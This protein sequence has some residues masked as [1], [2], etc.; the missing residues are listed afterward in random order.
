MIYIEQLKSSNPKPPISLVDL[1]HKDNTLGNN[2]LGIYPATHLLKKFINEK[3]YSISIGSKYGAAGVDINDILVTP[4]N[5]IIETNFKQLKA[6][7]ATKQIRLLKQYCVILTDLEEGGATYGHMDECLV[8]Y[9]KKLSIIP[10]RIISVSS[11]FNQT[12]RPDLN[13]E[14]VYIPIWPIFTILANEFYYN[15]MFDAELKA[16]RRILLEQ[17]N[18]KFG[19]FPNKKPRFHRVSL[20]AELNH[21]DLLKQFDWSLIYSKSPLGNENDYGDFIKSPNNFRF[22][23]TIEEYS[24][25]KTSKFLNQYE[26]P[27]VF[28]DSKHKTFGDSIGPAEQWFSN[29]K[30]YISTETYTQEHETS[31][32]SVGF[33]T[34][35]TFKA[36]CIGSYPFILGVPGSVNAVNKIGFKVYDH[37]YD[38]IENTY[39]RM[40]AVCNAV[41]MQN[42]NPMHTHEL[43]LHNFDLITDPRFLASLVAEPLNQ[44]FQPS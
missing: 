14:C 5:L 12:S 8:S 24:N 27:R 25:S 33:I 32:G 43:A 41:E 18:K 2:L 31:F 11:G 1:L 9:L 4:Q 17:P 38:Q 20:L 40:L 6:L 10:K 7:P 19:L 26:F 37:G 29:Y 35:K 3:L 22:N 42:S 16:H 28:L 13:I 44:V 36:F 15:M 34:E 23:D 21:R 39:E 30:F